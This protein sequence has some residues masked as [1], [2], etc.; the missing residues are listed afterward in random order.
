M[1]RHTIYIA[2]NSNLSKLR[3]NTVHLTVTSPPYV[4]TEFKRGQ[5]FDYDGFLEHFERTCEE[6]HRVTVD[7]GRF[8]LNVADIITKYRYTDEKTITRIPLGSDLLSIA[9][10]VGWRLLERFIWDKGFTRN[11]GGP[12]LGSYPYPM[13]I[14]N[15]NYFE[16]VY[17]LK[18]RGQRRTKQPV[19]EKSRISLE[20]WRTW[21]QQ[22]WR[23]ESISE[24]INYHR[25]VFPIDI[26]YR[27]IRMYSYVGDKILDPYMG[28]GATMIAAAKCGRRSVGFEIDSECEQWIKHRVSR[29]ME[30]GLSRKPAYKI[31]KIGA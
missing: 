6:I 28:T 29:E 7:G 13:S 24:R 17:V 19:R 11:F 3:G 5:E 27:L 16:Y 26:P 10:K 15:N 23:V 4:T 1:S 21:S 12:L 18:K 14:F 2:D 30:N 31:R 9:Q 20:E 25:A 22:W 8:A